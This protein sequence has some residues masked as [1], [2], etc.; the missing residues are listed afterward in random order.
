MVFQELP[1][2]VY[3]D[4]PMCAG[5]SRVESTGEPLLVGEVPSP[6]FDVSR[7]LDG[8]IVASAAFRDVCADVPGVT[9][10]PLPGVDQLWMLS[11]DPIVRIEPFDTRVRSGPPCARCGRPRYV[12]RTGPISLVDDQELP[13]GFSRT[14]MEFGDSADFGSTQPVLFRPDVLVDRQTARLLKAAPLLGV[15][16]IVQP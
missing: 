10:A 3:G 1:V 11:V 13:S 15:H 7:T 2:F 4:A 14:D 5:C 16:L 12:T 9:F 6:M 8:A